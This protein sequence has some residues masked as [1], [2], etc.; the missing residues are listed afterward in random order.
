M[1]APSN[2][3][4]EEIAPN[5]L[6]AFANANDVTTCV[7]LS[8]TK[9]NAATAFPHRRDKNAQGRMGGEP[10]VQFAPVG[11]GLSL[12]EA[13]ADFGGALLTPTMAGRSTRSPIM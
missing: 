8:F 10:A 2:Y 3:S 12:A 5:A 6:A 11:P 7:D 1:T 13:D 4:N 9:E